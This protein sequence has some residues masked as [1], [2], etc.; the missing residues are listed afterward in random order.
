MKCRDTCP[1]ETQKGEYRLLTTCP[2]AGISYHVGYT[3]EI[4]NEFHVGLEVALVRDRENKYDSKAV[5]VALKD[6]VGD[7]PDAFDF[8][9]ILGYIP[10]AQND[11][12]CAIIDS[13]R[14]ESLYAVLSEVN[15]G[16]AINNRLRLSVYTRDEKS[17]ETDIPGANLL[18]LAGLSPSDFKLL[19]EQL[20]K[21][22][23][24]RFDCPGD[25]KLHFAKGDEAV[26]LHVNCR[27]AE[28]Y[29]LK[30]VAT[31]Q[32]AL[33]ISRALG[34]REED[35]AAS[36]VWLANVKGPMRVDAGPLGFLVARSFDMTAAW[37]HLD[38]TASDCFRELIKEL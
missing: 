13:G 26:V 27:E 7:N 16:D 30:V 35:M 3:D 14:A 5:A 25:M 20:E 6:D 36:T 8:D 28:M 12:I 1:G 33:A 37:S 9:F 21:T 32:E 38:K 29:L 18:R 4:W 23:I 15:F 31:G 34:Y 11:E 24:I 19:A 22:G 10:R 17:N 2:I